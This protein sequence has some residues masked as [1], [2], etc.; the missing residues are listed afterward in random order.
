MPP[1]STLVSL[2]K[3]PKIFD[4]CFLY[5]AQ[6]SAHIPFNIK[7]VY[8][9]T[10]ADTN[11]PR[12]HHA[13]KETK[14]VMFCIQGSINLRLDNGKKREKITLDRPDIGVL[15]DKMIWHEMADFKKDT[16][17]LVLASKVFNEKDYIR[18]YEKFKKE[19]AKIH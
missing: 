14:Q 3:I 13:H 18:D 7:R 1:Q 11:L 9:I 10:K 4:D 2:I 19:T 8:F 12:G 6:N 16:I 15:I 5:F 17:L